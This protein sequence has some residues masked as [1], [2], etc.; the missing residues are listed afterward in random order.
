MTELDRAVVSIARGDASDSV[1]VWSGA[2][3][4]VAS[5]VFARLVRHL[6]AAVAL[7]DPLTPAGR[8]ALAAER[9]AGRVRARAS[10]TSS[11]ARTTRK[12]TM[13]IQE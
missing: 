12:S 1:G 11:S 2:P 7:A 6:T 13:D 5:E 4:A 10:R 9:L 8:A 3:S